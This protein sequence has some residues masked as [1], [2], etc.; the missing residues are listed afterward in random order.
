MQR[1]NIENFIYISMDIG[2]GGGII[3]N[4]RFSAAHLDTQERSGIWQ[5][6]CLVTCVDV[7]KLAVWKHWLATGD[8]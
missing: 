8:C 5:S 3:A 2:V 6:T 7:A 4:G 1:R